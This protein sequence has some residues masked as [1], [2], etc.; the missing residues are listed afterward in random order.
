MSKAEGTRGEGNHNE[1]RITPGSRINHFMSQH[2]RAVA[3]VSTLAR[4][5]GGVI[6]AG[7]ILTERY[8]AALA[9]HIAFSALDKLDGWAAR[10]SKEG[11]TLKGGKLDPRVDKFY[12]AV[13][14]IAL[15]R[16]GLM[17]KKHLVREVRDVGM[18]FA[19]RPYYERKKGIEDTSAANSGKISSLAVT[20]V[21]GV[22]L[23]KQARTNP[24][25]NEA[26][27]TVASSLKV[28][29][30]ITYPRVWVERQRKKDQGDK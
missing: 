11:P 8:R 6:V 20:L 23:T 28:R 16:K 7:L 24:R 21:E 27:Q 10:K 2:G 25:M 19:I 12:S 4:I 13:V 26:V 3:D 15:V 9:A 30:M 14:D 29:S 22:A 1:K 18:S 17:S 5:P